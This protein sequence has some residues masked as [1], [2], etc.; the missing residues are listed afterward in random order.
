MGSGVKGLSYS[1]LVID[2]N[3]IS[4]RIK[5]LIHYYQIYVTLNCPRLLHVLK[6]S[7]NFIL[8]QLK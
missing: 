3:K 4:Y 2:H 6:N 1:Q 8:Q 7:D 5:M